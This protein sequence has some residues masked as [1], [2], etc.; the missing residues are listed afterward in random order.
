MWEAIINNGN[1]KNIGRKTHVKNPL[2][3]ISKDHGHKLVNQALIKIKVTRESQ[4]TVQIVLNYQS[5]SKTTK[6]K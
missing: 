1:N 2:N 5:N 3:V 6:I 4:I